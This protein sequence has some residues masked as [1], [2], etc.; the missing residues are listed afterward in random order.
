MYLLFI[1]NCLVFLIFVILYVLFILLIRSDEAS[2]GFLKFNV[3]TFFILLI[4]FCLGRII[5]SIFEF[6]E[7]KTGLG[8]F[9]YF[10]ITTECLFNIFILYYLISIYA[11]KS[12]FEKR[13]IGMNGQQILFED[14][15]VL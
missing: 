1:V 9:E 11:Q 8:N 7:S 2:F 12:D 6:K 3:N 10:N 14:K 5:V 15:D 4:G 13:T